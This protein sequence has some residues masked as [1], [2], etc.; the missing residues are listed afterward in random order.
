VF[1]QQR[2]DLKVPEKMPPLWRRY[3]RFWRS[4]IAAD[5]DDEFAFHIEECIDE[6]VAGGMDPSAAREAAMR[7]MQE[8]ERVKETCRVMAL[9]QEQSMKRREWVSD[10]RQ[11]VSYAWRNMLAHPGMTGAIVLTIALGIGATTSLFSVVNAVLLRP[12]PYA[13]PHRVVTLR[14]SIGGGMG[15]VGTGVFTTWKDESRSFESATLV[16]GQTFN[17][18]DGEPARFSGMRVTPD[19][20][21]VF[22]L[23]PLLGRYFLPDETAES[24]VVVLTYG[25]WQARFAGDSGIVG[26]SIALNGE[27]HTVVG[28]TPARFAPTPL[29]PQL[30]TILTL[31]PQQRS[32]FGSHTMQAYAKLKPG[33]TIEQ[34]QADLDRVA[35]A[36]RVAHPQQMSQRGAAVLAYQ[37]WTIG[38]YDTQLW[39]LLG[40]VTVVLMIG[41]VN[42]ASLLLARAAARRKE[43]AI[44]GALGGGRGRLVRQLMTESLVVSLAG[45]ALG[46]VVAVNGIRFLVGAGPANIPRLGEATLNGGVLLFAT[47]ATVLCGLMFGLAPALRATRMDLQHVLRDGGRG[48][49]GAVRDRLRAGLIVGEIA[50]TL[51]LLIGASLLL[52]SSWRLQQVELGFE[53]EGVTM[54]RVSLPADRYDSVE[55]INAAFSRIMVRMQALPGVESAGAGTRVPM[56]G[57]SFEFGISVD[58]RTEGEVV[59][60]LRMISTGYFEAL[61][62][63]LRT[64]RLFN[65]TDLTSG[66]APVV[67]VNERF[68]RSVFGEESPLGRRI[69][70]WVA[71]EGVPEWREIVGV[72]GDVRASGQ[73]R[74]VPP[75]VYAPY[76]QARQGWWNAHQRT[77]A[78]VVKS[79]DGTAMAPAMRNVLKEFD[80]LLPVFDVQ[81]LARVLEQ[82]SAVRRFNTILLSLLGATGLLLA[83]IGIYGVIAFF[84]SQR[85]HEIG[86]RVALG[87]STGEIV[88]VVV[89]EA[90]ML[91]TVGI[92]VGALAALWATRVL[93]NMLYDIRPNDPVA[94]GI[95][96]A[97]L[98]LVALGASLLPARRAARVDPVK[99]LSAV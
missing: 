5:V 99:A 73:D 54:L 48:S 44:R 16:T 34:A 37:D 29:G 52:R 8:L 14:E 98:M 64:G 19:Y 18:T 95:G 91:A 45:G 50:V 23:R 87:A 56:L 28:V 39:V 77:M 21:R 78:L 26:R 43:I 67:I 49:R 36:I 4:D 93:A 94:F 59:G 53:P 11:D 66:A 6:L 42:V 58:G 46:L 7:R 82:N 24:R 27:S 40:A 41:C 22:E 57:T 31:T 12:L 15:S 3:L 96:A 10:I 33:V 1:C 75:E 32:N 86:V 51:V 71:D 65:E 13:D 38:D 69:S 2:P 68:A 9:E 63:P 61:G 80:P 35:A 76:T 92:A 74:D 90:L 60:N 83:T 25:L 30:M 84:V 72:I 55:V 88:G 47:L 89:R 85:T 81:P 20:F 17:L 70:G 62:I 97:V 79:R